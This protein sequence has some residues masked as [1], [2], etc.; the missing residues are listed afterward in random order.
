MNRIL[1]TKNEKDIIID[2]LKK[3]IQTWQSGIENIERSLG[4]SRMIAAEQ[5]STA[6]TNAA[7]ILAEAE[8]IIAANHIK[9]SNIDQEI[10]VL[11]QE[12]DTYS[13]IIHENLNTA[14]A[15]AESFPTAFSPQLL[16]GQNNPD[17]INEQP[18]NNPALIT[19]KLV[20]FLNAKHYMVFGNKKGAT[21]G[22][23]WQFQVETAV[24][25]QDSSF[26]K[27]EDLDRYIN[28]MIAPYQRSVLNEVAPFDR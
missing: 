2:D 14:P 3:E 27:F 9:I 24:S 19:M 28:K 23:S 10:A 25:V 20:A 15:S 8:A 6:N 26:V 5:Q 17:S 16:S 21:H 12:L 18:V 1:Q 4:K 7:K 11:H 22:H 13:Q